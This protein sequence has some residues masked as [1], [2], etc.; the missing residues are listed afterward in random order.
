MKKLILW[1]MVCGFSFLAAN[2]NADAG[3]SIFKGAYQILSPATPQAEYLVVD[4][5]TLQEIWDKYADSPLPADLVP[6]KEEPTI[7]SGF[8]NRD[9]LI[10]GFESMAL[11]TDRY[12]R[13]SNNQNDVLEI[14]R[15][16]D[17]Q[18]DSATKESGVVNQYLLAAPVPFRF[19]MPTPFYL[20]ISKI[21]TI[22]L[23]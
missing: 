7:I 16:D 20:D 3:A 21:S 6:Y 11:V 23:Q 18:Y 1:A 15:R 4:T 9:F 10:L 12:L 17:G 8:T 2:K 14:Y 22:L 13:M 5:G 19:H